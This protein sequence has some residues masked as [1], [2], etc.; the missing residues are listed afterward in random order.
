LDFIDFVEQING[1]LRVIKQKVRKF[2]EESQLRIVPIEDV[3]ELY[4]IIKNIIEN[5]QKE[6][7][8]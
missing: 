3:E 8:F 4:F 2:A 7:S 6:R 1:E 5:T